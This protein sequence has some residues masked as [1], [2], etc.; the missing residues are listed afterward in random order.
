M[1]WILQLKEHFTILSNTID[2]IL[3][4]IYFQLFSHEKVLLLNIYVYVYVSK[5]MGM[6]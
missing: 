4:W 5:S 3:V 1:M 6:G 2:D